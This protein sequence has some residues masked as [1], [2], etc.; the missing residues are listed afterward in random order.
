MEKKIQISA[1]LTACIFTVLI[2]TLIQF[3]LVKNTY[4]LNRDKYYTAV[5]KSMLVITSSPE[6]LALEDGAREGLRSSAERYTGG[7]LSKDNFIADLKKGTIASLRLSS[8]YLAQTLRKHPELKGVR[9]KSQYDQIIV[10]HNGL[11]DTL[12]NEGMQ[13]LAFLGTAARFPNSV[14]LNRDL[15]VTKADKSHELNGKS[16]QSNLRILVRQSNYVDISTW[17]TEVLSRMASVFVMAAGLILAVIILFYL[18]F[19]ALIRQKK[20]AEVKTDFANNVIHELK[21]PLSS[22]NLILKSI[23][24]PDVQARPEMLNDLLLTL[25]RQHAKIQNL[26]DSVLESAMVTALPANLQEV[27]IT[28]VLRQHLQDM[29]IP[30][31]PLKIEIIPDAQVISTDVA[32]VE[33][34][35]NIL[36]DNAAKYSDAG[37]PVLVK[38]YLKDQSYVIAVTDQGPGIPI[39][40]QQYIFDKFYRV[41]EQDT[42][43]VKGLGLGLYLAQQ[44][45][46]QI[47]AK[48]SVKPENGPGCT[49]KIA[50][51]L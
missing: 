47:G 33:K 4:I 29:S 28:A 50:L 48:L 17:K 41:P 22:V 3:Y 32:A 30:G 44:A 43:T 8:Q 35:I 45:A 36:V 23:K 38:G 10:E 15:A 26:V 25:E 31:H 40:V 11:A 6:I 39:P 49:F 20:I 16:E 34:I 37:K 2:L 21:T 46:V 19:R 12:L 7:H 42:H 1:L 14:L 18:V 51:P 9:F 13:P 5:R 24:R 27:E